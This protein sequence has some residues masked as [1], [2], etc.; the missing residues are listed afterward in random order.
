MFRKIANAALFLWMLPQNL[1][2][3]FLLA[4]T[5]GP[6]YVI[7]NRFKMPVCIRYKNTSGGSVSLGN[8]IFISRFARMYTERHE[9]GHTVQ[10]MILGPLYLPLIGIPS[11]TWAGLRRAGAFKNKSYFWF[12]TERWAD[13]IAQ[14]KRAGK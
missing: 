13:K 8:F 14:I 11:I 2:G 9:L 4:T 7:N 1:I 3:L 10:S 5:H 6:R 12:Y